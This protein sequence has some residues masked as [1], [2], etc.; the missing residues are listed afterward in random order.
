[1]FEPTNPEHSLVDAL[2]EEIHKF[3]GPE[4]VYW[5]H[6]TP[7]EIDAATEDATPGGD[8]YLDDLDEVYGEKS[9]GD[10][11]LEFFEPIM[12]YGKVDVEPIIQE[13]MRLGLI[14]TEQLDLYVNIAHAHEKLERPPNG[15]DVFRITFLIRDVDG[16]LKEKLVYY[17]VSNC[18]P[19]DLYNYQYVNYQINGEQTNMMDV[20]DEIKNYFTDNEF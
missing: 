6:K 13:L 8:S 4:L 9:S 16:E 14:E 18:H 19:V 3:E 5:V 11:K 17:K 20:P 7:Q 15:G 1:M 10:A 2:T 12:V